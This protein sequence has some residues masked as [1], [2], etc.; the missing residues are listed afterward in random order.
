MEVRGSGIPTTVCSAGDLANQLGRRSATSIK[1]GIFALLA[2][3]EAGGSVDA[4]LLKPKATHLQ[5][6]EAS[7][8][9]E[10]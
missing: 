8:D 3:Q 2:C 7:F 1:R 6:E 10:S 9:F 4:Q 5:G